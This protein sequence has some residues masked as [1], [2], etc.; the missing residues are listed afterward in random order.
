MDRKSFST[1]NFCTENKKTNSPFNEAAK[2][3]VF[4]VATS[5]RRCVALCSLVLD[6]NIS[7]PVDVLLGRV[8][9]ILRSLNWMKLRGSDV[10]Q[11]SCVNAKQVCLVQH[12][13]ISVERPS[14][15]RSDFVNVWRHA[16][17]VIYT[18]LSLMY[19]FALICL[20]IWCLF[21][22]LVSLF[23]SLHPFGKDVL[24]FCL[25]QAS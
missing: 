20:M 18:Y 25:D 23:V 10:I 24:M 12:S 8:Q 3:L 7:L 4:T 16:R 11:G 2:L 9:S 15:L 22:G 1:S 19:A 21:R 6:L 14:Y 5:G 13:L 17:L